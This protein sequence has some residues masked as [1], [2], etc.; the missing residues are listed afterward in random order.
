M[1]IAS[2]V[3]NSH[4]L[5]LGVTR[6][7]S[8]PSNWCGMEETI[9]EPFSLLPKPTMSVPR[10]SIRN[11]LAKAKPALHNAAER[12]TKVTLVI[13]NES[14]GTSILGTSEFVLLIWILFLRRTH[15]LSQVRNASNF[16]HQT[17][18]L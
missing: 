7:F 18:I 5:D 15:W 8:S 6:T 4:H 13:G 1:S 2:K 3:H 14:A 10:I 16:E 12:G 11:F 17:S 9:D